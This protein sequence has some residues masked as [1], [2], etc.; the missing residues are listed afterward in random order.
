MLWWC[1]ALILVARVGLLARFFSDVVV[2]LEANV[3]GIQLLDDAP[4]EQSIQQSPGEQ[5]HVHLAKQGQSKNGSNVKQLDGTIKTQSWQQSRGEPE[6]NRL[7]KQ[8]QD[9]EEGNGKLA[10]SCQ[11]KLIWRL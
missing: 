1:V 10:K 5:K 2:A 9:K 4:K 8:G 11:Y 7:A 3:E 6:Q